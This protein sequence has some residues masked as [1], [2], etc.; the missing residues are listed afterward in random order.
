MRFLQ[1]PCLIFKSLAAYT[2]FAV[3]RISPLLLALTQIC[4]F[5]SSPDLQAIS[6]NGHQQLINGIRLLQLFKQPPPYS[7][8]SSS[9]PDLANMMSHQNQPTASHLAAHGSSPDLLNSRLGQQVHGQTY[10]ESP[11]EYARTMVENGSSHHQNN[12]LFYHHHQLHHQLPHTRS[13]EPIYENFPLRY[14]HDGGMRARTSSIQSAPEN[15][16]RKQF[17]F[18]LVNETFDHDVNFIFLVQWRLLKP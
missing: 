3:L 15:L 7:S 18:D 1:K 12:V 14:S 16:P 17:V 4:T 6:D 5:L 2:Q 13:T 8:I 9:T 11:H 10:Q